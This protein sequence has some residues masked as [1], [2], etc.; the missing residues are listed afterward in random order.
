MGLGS[1][2]TA[3]APQHRWASAR[4]AALRLVPAA[5]LVWALIAGL[6]LLLTHVFRTTLGRWDG[7]VDRWLAAHRS[8]TWNSTTHVL[9]S[10]VET[11]PVIVVGV[12][13]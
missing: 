5:V 1:L 13:G 7:P 10:A 8:G 6:G 4:D 2:G 11:L 12:G 3:V 9:S